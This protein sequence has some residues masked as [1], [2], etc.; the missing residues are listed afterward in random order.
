MM[1]RVSP[2]KPASSLTSAASQAAASLASIPLAGA[3]LRGASLASASR[4]VALLASALLAIAPAHAQSQVS[5][6]RLFATPAERATMEAS[7]GASA[8]LAPNSQGQQPAAGTPGGPA[9]TA[10]GGQAGDPAGQGGGPGIKSA[11]G[12]AAAQ[13]PGGVAAQ[14]PGGAA[15]AGGPGGVRNP[16]GPAGRPAAPPSPPALVMTGVLRRS[17]NR[18]T[19]WLNGEPQYG[20][21]KNLSQRRGAAT[22]NLT[23]TLPSGKK[24]TLKA[25]QR[26]DLNEG[27]VKDINEP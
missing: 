24:I 9:A 20:A 15:F 13:G 4:A 8:A 10:D 14:G 1:P 19:V 16:G 26:Y 12:S 2:I 27:R 17:D 18:T 7:R 11:D 22:P 25:G 6:G 23:V 3:S 21:Q 5:L